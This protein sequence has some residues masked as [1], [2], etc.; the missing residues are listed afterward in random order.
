MLGIER[1]EFCTL[2]CLPGESCRA[3]LRGKNSPGQIRTAATRSLLAP[4]ERR[5]QSL[6]SLTARPR[7]CERAQS[8]GPICAFSG[9]EALGDD[10]HDDSLYPQVGI[11]G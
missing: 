4:A 2:S 9:L 11:S 6:V 8:H 1:Y 7:G 3:S 5:I 10:E